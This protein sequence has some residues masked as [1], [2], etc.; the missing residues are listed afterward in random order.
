MTGVPV[1]DDQHAMFVAALNK[2]HDAFNLKLSDGEIDGVVNFL[3]IYTKTHFSAE[4]HY[5]RLYEY[6]HCDEHLEQHQRF[7][8]DLEQLKAALTKN[9][10]QVRSLIQITA[11]M[12][13]W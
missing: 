3:E 7:F 8:S 11:L 10:T 2:L 12:M 4:E 5:M 6:P 9:S 1:I 13:R